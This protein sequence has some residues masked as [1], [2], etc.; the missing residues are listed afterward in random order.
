[1]MAPSLRPARVDQV[2]L[3]WINILHAA[4]LPQAALDFPPTDS[5]TMPFSSSEDT[6]INTPDTE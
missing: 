1:M 6:P 2:G 3:C 4:L 5:R